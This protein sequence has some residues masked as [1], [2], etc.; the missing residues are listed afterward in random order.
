[1]TAGTTSSLG[2]TRR[3]PTALLFVFVLAGALGACTR[4]EWREL[5]VNDGGFGVLMRG[6]PH[7]PRQQLDTPA[8][9]LFAHLY[10]SDR[11]DSYFMVGYT[12]Y[13]LALVVGTAPEQLFSGVRETWVQRIDGK[14]TANDSSIKLAGK[15]PDTEFQAADK[16]NGLDIWR[17]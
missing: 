3:H 12:D 11:P 16:I 5:P 10:S 7:Y 1:M 17:L 6:E 4:S 9:K 2:A 14:L 8:G 15:Y 13:P